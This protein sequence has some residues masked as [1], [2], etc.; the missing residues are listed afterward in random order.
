MSNMNRVYLLL[1][2]LAMLLIWYISTNKK[3]KI[4]KEL[5][6]KVLLDS[7]NNYREN[8]KNIL[9]SST[10]SKKLYKTLIVLVHPDN[11]NNKKKIDAENLSSK[12]TN[13]KKD[14]KTLIELEKEV[15]EFLK[16]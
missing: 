16:N 1:L 13:A 9:L 7:D 11:Y 12:I 10:K 6:R 4:R 14:Y 3:R 8:A 15:K 5:K 2:V